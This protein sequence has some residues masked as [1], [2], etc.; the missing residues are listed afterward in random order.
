LSIEKLYG[1]M[2]YD[3]NAIYNWLVDYSVKNQNIEEHGISI[4]LHD[5]EGELFNIKI[6][7]EINMELMKSYIEEW[8]KR[9]IDKMKNEG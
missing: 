4:D 8:F 6:W 3:E 5:L 9:A 7:H 1:I 2:E